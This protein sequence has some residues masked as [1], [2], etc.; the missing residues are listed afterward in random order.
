MTQYEI[1][2]EIMIAFDIEKGG[3]VDEGIKC[4]KA[5]ERIYNKLNQGQS[6]PID[7][8]VVPFVCRDCD[9]TTKEYRD[10]LC[11]PCHKWHTNS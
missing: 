8:V 1:L 2:K 10:N 9:K 11:E 4:T 7:S 3:T 5:A 6:L